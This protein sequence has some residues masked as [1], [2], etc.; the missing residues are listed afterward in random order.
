VIVLVASSI[1][2]TEYRFIVFDFSKI[3]ASNIIFIIWIGLLLMPFVG[4]LE[5]MGVK[6]KK[7]VKEAKKSIDQDINRLEQRINTI[8]IKS[9]IS[10]YNAP[11][12]NVEEVKEKEELIESEIKKV[13]KIP[14]EKESSSKKNKTA[15]LESTVAKIIHNRA[16][17]RT[18]ISKNAKILN[19]PQE[20][21]VSQVTSLLM[22]MNM[23]NINDVEIIYDIEKIA[24]RVAN[25]EIVNN[26]YIDYVDKAFPYISGKLFVASELLANMKVCSNCGM[27]ATFRPDGTCTNCGYCDDD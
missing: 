10:I 25:G 8:S 2:I 3:N 13:E 14:K 12:P 6:V 19:I 23:L 27:R 18:L 26:E 11:L 7:E 22:K 4:E 15:G 1:Y 9:A 17:I 5:V 20:N 24:N 21:D 16:R